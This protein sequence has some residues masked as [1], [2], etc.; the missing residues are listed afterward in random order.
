MIVTDDDVT[1]ALFYL[2]QEP[3]PLA[4]AEYDL[5]DAKNKR[6]ELFAE[7]FGLAEG[8]SVRDRECWVE[9]NQEYVAA[10]R[11]EAVALRELT[12]HKARTRWADTITKLWQTVNANARAA[13]R[14]R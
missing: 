11:Q 3:H 13:E 1:T 10:R 7:L 5:A 4:R 12:R 2:A 9:T 14:V 8:K 6:E